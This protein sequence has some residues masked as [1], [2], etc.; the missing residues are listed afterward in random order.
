MS[1]RFLHTLQASDKYHHYLVA[2]AEWSGFH[3][4]TSDSISRSLDDADPKKGH[5]RVEQNSYGE[6][7]FVWTY[8]LQVTESF[9]FSYSARAESVEAACAAALAYQPQ[10]CT[11][12]YLDQS[13]VLYG[14]T[15]ADGFTSWEVDMDGDVAEITGPYTRAASE[16]ERWRWERPWAPASAVLALAD[17]RKLNGWISDFR[18]AVI[19]AVDSPELFKRACGEVIANIK[20]LPAE[21]RTNDAS[22][23]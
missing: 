18:G 3:Y 19:A 11:V 10:T 16:K 21:I 17:C 9:L 4:G 13:Y 12:K 15:R 6:G 14:S 20:E 2:G 1:D 7:A 23:T 5:I 22:A 8:Y